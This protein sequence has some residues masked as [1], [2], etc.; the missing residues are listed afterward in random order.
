MLDRLACLAA[1]QSRAV[2]AARLFGAAEAQ[3]DEIGGALMHAERLTF[4]THLALARA[5]LD[6]ATWEV[7]LAEGRDQ[8]ADALIDVAVADLSTT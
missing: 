8:H 5:Q 6:P 4:E 3:R 2:Q 7:L 1:A